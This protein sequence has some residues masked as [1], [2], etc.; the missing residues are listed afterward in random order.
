MRAFIAAAE[1]GDDVW[2]E[3]PTINK[4]QDKVAAYFGKERSGSMRNMMAVEEW[5]GFHAERLEY[6]ERALHDLLVSTGLVDTTAYY[7]SI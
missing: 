2:S 6:A 5:E 7:R 3:D 4:L 1:V